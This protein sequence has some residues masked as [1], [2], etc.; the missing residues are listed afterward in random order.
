[1]KFGN[2]AL[3]LS[4]TLLGVFSLSAGA[5]GDDV[6]TSTS[7]SG[8]SSSSTS[9]SS[10][11]SSSSGSSSSSSSGSSSSSSSTSSSSSSSSGSGSAEEKACAD[12]SAAI[13]DQFEKCAPF[14]VT[15]SYGDK[16]TCEQRIV[17][18]C[19]E[20]FTAPGNTTKVA[21]V[22][23]CVAALPGAACIDLLNNNFPAPCSFPPGTFTDTTGCGGDFQCQSSNCVVPAGSACGTCQ[24][25]SAAGGACTE[26]GEC[27]KGLICAQQ[28]C[29]MPGKMGDS[30]AA[31][32]CSA[33]LVCLNG[34]CQ[35]PL[36]LGD[37]C[38]P[39]MQINQQ[40]CNVGF[41]EVCGFF[42]N[43]CETIQV[44]NAGQACGLVNGAVTLCMGD[45]SCEGAFGSQKCVAKA[46]DGGAC[47]PQG[48]PQCLGPAAC[49][50]GMCAVPDPATCM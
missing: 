15:L 9:G 20:S 23:A 8:S 36:M 6:T 11:S 50:N 13:C 10:S 1:M 35:A 7:T 14:L 45:S 31:A 5:C 26:D 42:T 19:V 32:P 2:L 17:F 21:D 16:A 29:V 37:T 38:T 40:T 12:L 22:D 43:K 44:A 25:K 33:T 39:S 41:G 30:C 18:N 28:K 3:G 27:E 48:G 34:T 46:A 4:L 24:A 49:V 47:N